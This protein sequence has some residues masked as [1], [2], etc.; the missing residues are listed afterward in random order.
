M[1]IEGLP[2]YRA[3]PE[4]RKLSISLLNIYICRTRLKSMHRA[5]GMALR[6]LPFPPPLISEGLRDAYPLDGVKERQ[7]VAPRSFVVHR[8]AV[9]GFPSRRYLHRRPEDNTI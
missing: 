2:F 3:S 8:K 1:N 4:Y 5:A 9:D 7:C 6:D